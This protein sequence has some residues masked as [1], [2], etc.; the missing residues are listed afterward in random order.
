MAIRRGGPDNNLR[1]QPAPAVHIPDSA[2]ISIP[3]VSHHIQHLSPFS[4]G[5][6]CLFTR[7]NHYKH[8][9]AAPNLALIA[10][11]ARLRL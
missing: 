2:I 6:Q 3:V 9:T 11:I 8:S 7:Q 5:L 10:N 1:K 4:C